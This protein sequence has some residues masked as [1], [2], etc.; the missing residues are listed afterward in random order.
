MK[1]TSCQTPRGPRAAAIVQDGQALVVFD[2]AMKALFQQENWLEYA[3]DFVAETLAD[4]RP[5][6]IVPMSGAEIL[7]IVPDP[8]KIAC[9]GLNYAD[10]A[11]ETGDTVPDCP[12]FFNKFP[13]ALCKSGDPVTLPAVSNFVDYEAELVIVI[14]KKG[15]NIPK[16]TAM[17]YVAGYTCGNDVSARDWQMRPP[18]RQWFLGKTFDG[19][20]PVGPWMV[21]PD[22]IPDPQTLEIE[23]R[24]NGQVMQHSNTKQFIFS[25]PTLINWVSQVSTLLP[26]DLIFTGT[27][28]GVGIGRNPKICLKDG[29][30]CEVEIEKIGVL[31]NQF[32]AE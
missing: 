27:P 7:P 18:A 28:P 16:E 1:L 2:C 20:A 21:T 13:T 29:D 5:P 24:V 3:K 32:K 6:C 26:G 19:F 23:M 25:V 4:R 17:D 31:R 22:E 9:V 14:G 10:H 30:V 11:A 15:R 8:Q 12:V